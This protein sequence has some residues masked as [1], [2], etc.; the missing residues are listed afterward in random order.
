MSL[1]SSTATVT[2]AHPFS[3]T[4]IDGVLPAGTYAV[5]TEEE[6]VEGVSF[7]AYRRLSTVLLLPGEAGSSIRFQALDVDP[8][9]LAEALRRDALVDGVSAPLPDRG[10]P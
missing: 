2:F 8:A 3:L 1:R 10:R 5:E 9:E 4:G 7:P 6:L